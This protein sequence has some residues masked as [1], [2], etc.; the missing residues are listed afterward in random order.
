MTVRE[1]QAQELAMK[2]IYKESQFILDVRNPSDFEEWKIE[3]EQLKHLNIP[4]FDLIDGVEDILDQ[5]P[6]DQEVLVVCA[7]EG[8]SVMVAEMLAEHG[9]NVAYLKGG[10][11]AW[12]EQLG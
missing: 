10:M 11:K 1:M 12:S 6:S 3:G 4:Y 8:S 2:A 7:K 5:I 9:R